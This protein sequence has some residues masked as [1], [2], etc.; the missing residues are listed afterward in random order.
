[1]GSFMKCSCGLGLM[2]CMF[3]AWSALAHGDDDPAAL[4]VGGDPVPGANPGS[5]AKGETAAKTESEAK[6]EAPAPTFRTLTEARAEATKN[7]HPMLV[8]ITLQGCHNCAAVKEV[9]KS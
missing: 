5:D 9:L 7:H 1:M 8:L 3:V 6:A 4:K 2:L